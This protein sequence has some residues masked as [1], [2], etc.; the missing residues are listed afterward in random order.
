MSPTPPEAL[1]AI[2]IFPLP[3]TV[4]LPGTFLSLHIFEPRYRAMMEYTIE[5]HRHMVVA[6]LDGQAGPDEHGRP[7]IFK[8]AG[9]GAL[10]RS[11]RLPDGRYNIVLEGVARVDISHELEPGLVFRRAHAELLED[12]NEVSA[13]S[14]GPAVAS[15]RALSLRAL[16]QPDPELVERIA[17]VSG[18]GHLADIVC[19]AA[20]QESLLR[21]Q[22]LSETRVGARLELVAGG[23]GEM[24]LSAEDAEDGPGPVLG[25][26]ITSGK[27]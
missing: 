12:I 10:R 20:F 8:T 1:N 27:A 7:A 11:V 18:A 13:T 9:L 6:M 19:A 5:G 3:G 14:L 21:Q 22:V 16:V 23:L 4:L 15:V 25:W 26:G 24:L 2:P 17:T